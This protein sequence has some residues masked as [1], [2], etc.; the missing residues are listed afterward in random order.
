VIL[1]QLPLGVAD[2]ASYSVELLSQVNAGSALFHHGD[3]GNE[4][5]V[6]PF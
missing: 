4:V 1:D 2:G 5:A 3:D 6:R